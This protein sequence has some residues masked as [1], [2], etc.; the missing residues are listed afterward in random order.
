MFSNGR[1][2]GNGKTHKH[3]FN[4]VSEP[5]TSSREN[6]GATKAATGITDPGKDRYINH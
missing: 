5:N 4:L 3:K 6:F 1:Q 2:G